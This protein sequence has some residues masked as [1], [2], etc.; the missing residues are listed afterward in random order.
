MSQSDPLFAKTQTTGTLLAYAGPM[1]ALSIVNM[2]LITYVPPFYAQEIGLDIAVV[3]FIFFLARA[4][5]AVIDPLVGNLSDRT[6][7]RWGRRKPWMAAGAP[8][9]MLCA[10][11]FFQPPEN[12][13]VPYLAIAA[14][15]FYAA[16]TVVIIPYISWGAEILRDYAGRTR[17]N[18][19]RE[20]AGICGTILATSLPLI[21]LP[22]LIEGEPSLKQ[23][24]GILAATIIIVLAI[25]VPV[26]LAKTPQ[27]EF[28]P[29]KSLGL[30]AALGLLR[31]NKPLLRLLCGVFIIWLGGA[32]YNALSLF[33]VS[34]ALEQPLSSFLWF[35][36]IQYILALVSVPLWA[37]FA[38][39][40]GRHRAL[41]VGALGFFIA[42]Q[43][44]HFVA[45]GDFTATVLVYVFAGLMTPVIWV[46]P[47]ALVADTVE[48]GMLKGGSDD[49]ALY[50]AL[51]TFI[52]KLALAIG[53]GFALPV[54]GALG[55]DPGGA[56]TAQGKEAL[57]IVALFAPGCIAFIGAILLWNYPITAAK[58][59]I[60]RRWLAR[61]EATPEDTH[62]AS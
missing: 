16:Y 28:R 40:F 14:F 26:A 25:T 29:H 18:S 27:G 39:H 24:L 50:M 37:K 31:K 10:W 44:F 38:E 33:W 45:P 32:A 5:D 47:P 7:T 48:Y 15:S 17:V 20:A 3:G 49:A 57:R 61:R 2:L 19:T 46:M 34:R 43:G 35:V 56:L 58:H 60:I 59:L 54:A 6:R 13:G 1:V 62:V 55:F 51:Y 21:V 22:L 9:F 11:A 12:V 41:V 30:F 52:Q 8:L 42:H 4:F 53:V 36:L 23:I